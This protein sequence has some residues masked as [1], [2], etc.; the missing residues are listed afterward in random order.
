MK[1]LLYSLQRRPRRSCNARF[2]LIATLRVHLPDWDHN[3]QRCSTVHSTAG[4]NE[5]GSTTICASNEV[6]DEETL[7]L[8]SGK[9]EVLTDSHFSGFTLLNKYSIGGA[10]VV[11]CV[12]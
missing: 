12:Q 11:A 5:N 6:L 10:S 9:T 8:A 1:V 3:I 2:L 4:S 7:A